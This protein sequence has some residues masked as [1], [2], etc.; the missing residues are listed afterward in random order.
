MAKSRTEDFKARDCEVITP[1]D[2]EDIE[3][4]SN[5]I[6]VGETGDL[7]VT[8]EKMDDGQSITFKDLAA[9][10]IHPMRVKRVWDTNTTADDIIAVY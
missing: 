7:A 10:V 6:Y 9:G 5:G 3:Y 2:S 1:N 8:L 4:I